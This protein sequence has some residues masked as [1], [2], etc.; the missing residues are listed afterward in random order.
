MQL[1]SILALFLAATATSAAVAEPANDIVARFPNYIVADASAL[2]DRSTELEARACNCGSKFSCK[3]SVTECCKNKGRYG[4]CNT[5]E[6][7][8]KCGSQ[9]NPLQCRW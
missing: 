9:C 2:L 1:Q 8:C 3:K 6:G 4:M 5:D 7:K